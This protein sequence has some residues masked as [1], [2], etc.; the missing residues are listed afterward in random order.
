MNLGKKARNAHEFFAR[1]LP[2]RLYFFLK[3][4]RIVYMKKA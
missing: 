2:E 1:M 4:Y 3:S